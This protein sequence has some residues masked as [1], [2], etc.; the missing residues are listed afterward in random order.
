[1]AELVSNEANSASWRPAPGS[2]RGQ[3]AIVTG[4]TSGLGLATAA[5]LAAAG[6]R[7]ILAVRNPDKARRVESGIRRAA[8]DAGVELVLPGAEV[9]ALDLLC[10]TSIRAFAAW[11]LV[12]Q[13][14]GL[15]I[16]V[17]NAGGAGEL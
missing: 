9:P 15:H 10:P 3:T 4:A 1:M 16:L 5:Q 12:T 6:A 8:G 7:V 11:V 17:N 2:L 13:Q 14:Q